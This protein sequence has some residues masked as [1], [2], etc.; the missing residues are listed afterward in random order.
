VDGAAYVEDFQGDIN[1]PADIRTEDDGS[2]SV[3]AGE[4]YNFHFWPSQ[5]RITYPKG[6]VKAVFTT[7]RARLIMDDREGT[8]DRDSARYVM[9]VGGDWWESLTAVWDNWTTNA[10]MGIGR[11]RFVQKE[12]KSFNMI[13]LPEDSIRKYPP[14]FHTTGPDATGVP[15]DQKRD[16][17]I[18]GLR[19]Y[20]N[21]SGNHLYV[22]HDCEGALSLEWMSVSGTIIHSIILETPGFVDTRMLQKGLY[23]LRLNG[24]GTRAISKIL[25]N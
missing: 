3:T 13:S 5:G 6:D 16:A 7:V 19:I 24:P 10:D 2:A 21:P 12:W 8:D 11:F 4:G 23:L 18:P 9:G 25:I 22:D 20:P 17:G 15:G 1:R 14:P